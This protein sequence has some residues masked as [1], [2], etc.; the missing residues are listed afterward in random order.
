M[1][2]IKN[3]RVYLTDR[4]EKLYIGE[5][6]RSKS[7]PITFLEYGKRICEVYPSMTDKR[8]CICLVKE[9]HVFYVLPNDRADESQEHGYATKNRS[10]VRP[11]EG[12]SFCDFSS[13]LY[14][15]DCSPWYQP[16]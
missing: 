4:A 14:R 6:F 10:H 9:N 7:S 15:H 11:V 1:K 12:H 3:Q 8:R 13:F 2:L 5:S 16:R